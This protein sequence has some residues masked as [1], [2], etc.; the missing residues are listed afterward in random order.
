MALRA[1]APG[2]FVLIT[3]PDAADKTLYAV[4][5]ILSG[6]EIRIYPLDNQTRESVL[7]F[8]EGKW[9]VLGGENMGFTFE[10]KSGDPEYYKAINDEA[11]KE[12]EVSGHPGRFEFQGHG[13]ESHAH[14]VNVPNIDA[15]EEANETKDYTDSLEELDLMYADLSDL[16]ITPQQFIHMMQGPLNWEEGPLFKPAHV[17]WLLKHGLVPKTYNLDHF[18]DDLMIDYLTQIDQV[19]QASNVYATL[20]SGHENDYVEDDDLVFYS[21]YFANKEV[22]PSRDELDNIVTNYLFNNAIAALLMKNLITFDSQMLEKIRS[23]ENTE[24]IQIVQQLTPTKSAM[25]ESNRS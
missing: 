16:R 8:R 3:S 12:F 15:L 21:D 10:F 1:I 19:S 23:G 17:E 13:E 18:L 20:Q 14:H 7:V 2:D 24:L 9:V 25:K 11:D 5:S 22:I 4:R 6:Q